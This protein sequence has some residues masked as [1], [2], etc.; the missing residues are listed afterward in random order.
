MNKNPTPS[1]PASPAVSVVEELRKLST[2]DLVAKYHEVYGKAPRIKHREFLW[3]RIAWKLTENDLGGLPNVAKARVEELVAQ[4]NIPRSESRRTVAGKL[5][6][7]Q[8]A[9]SLKVGTVLQKTWRDQVIRVRV[10]EA[11]FEHNG[12]TYKSLS[13]VAKAVTN[14]HWN[15]LLFFGLRERKPRK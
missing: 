6:P 2:D 7:S 14:T 3:K 4:I 13:A 9:A 12:E 5:K 1:A 11:G 10:T 8:G 15:G